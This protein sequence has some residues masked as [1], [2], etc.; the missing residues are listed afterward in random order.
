MT[1]KSTLGRKG[2]FKFI[3]PGYSPLPREIEA[4]TEV[5]AMEEYYCLLSF[6]LTYAQLVFLHSPGPPA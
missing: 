2:L 1:E 6:S 5:E 3:F 4:E